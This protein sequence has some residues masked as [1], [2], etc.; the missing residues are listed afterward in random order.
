MTRNPST[1]PDHVKVSIP[2]RWLIVAA[3]VLLGGGGVAGDLGDLSD[4]VGVGKTDEGTRDRKKADERF[5]KID[6]TLG[7]HTE[8]IGALATET[9]EIKQVQHEIQTVQHQ[10]IASQEARRVTEKEPNRRERERQYDVLNAL[11]LK[12]LKAGKPPCVDLRCGE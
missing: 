4:Y 7:E 1:P 6:M 8:Q 10:A 2:R 9:G 5:V 11:N 12:R 3:L